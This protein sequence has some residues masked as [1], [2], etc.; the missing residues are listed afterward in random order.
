MQPGSWLDE[1]REKLRENRVV[2]G[3]VGLGY[4]GLPLSLLYASKGFRVIGYDIDQGRVEAIRRG[5]S[6]INYIPDHEV[7]RVVKEGLLEAYTSPEPLHEADFILVT[8]PTP[9]RCNGLPDLS[10]VRSAARSVGRVLRRGQVVVLESSTY[11][12]TT[13]E[14]LAPILEEESGLR[15]VRD[16]GVAYSPERI[17][18]GDTRYKLEDIPKVVGGITPEITD[19]V[20]EFYS[21]AFKYVVKVKDCKTAEAT[22][23]LEN[24]FRYIN[25]ALVNELAVAFEKMGIN[26][27]E[28]IEAAKTK[29]FGFMAFYPGPGVGG[30]CIPVDPFYLRYS[31]WRHG[32]VLRLVEVAASIN[33]Y[34]PVHVVNL[35]EEGLAKLGKRI[36]GARVAVLGLAYKPDVNDARESPSI[37]II[38]ELVERGA[39]VRVHDPLVESVKTVY[40]VFQSTVDPLELVGWA[41]AVVIAVNHT[42]Y[43]S[44]ELVTK[45]LNPGKELVVVDT[46]NLLSGARPGPGVVLLRLGAPHS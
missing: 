30:H 19:I 32:A 25:I 37:R 44:K 46:R 12:G 21:K 18:P 11:P 40:G 35:V 7:A 45:L 17:N 39:V 28:V 15:V 33:N 1:L 4:V 16:F 43:H 10:Y 23:M 24:M 27:W 26:V 14:V 34:M 22:K 9:L 42:A 2:V 8:V 36:R 13:R 3:V 6:Y 5:R 31:A 38:E 41:D 29:P 20:A